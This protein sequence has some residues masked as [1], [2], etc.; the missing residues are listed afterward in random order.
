V[1]INK[2]FKIFDEKI[3]PGWYQRSRAEGRRAHFTAVLE[4]LHSDIEVVPSGSWARGTSLDPI[5][6]VDLILVLP[7]D[8]RAVYD[9]GSGS[10]EAVLKYVAALVVEMLP[11]VHRV[12]L[13]NHVVR[14]YLDST[15]GTDYEG[16]RGFAV[17][18]M[19][20]FRDGSGVKVPERRDDRWRTVDPENL[21]AA[22]HRRQQAW[23][24]YT[25]MVRLL[26]DWSREHP[27]LHISPL[28]MEVLALRCLPHPPW[29]RRM[30][31][32]EALKRFFTAAA[33]EIMRGVHD[34]AGRSGEIAPGLHRRAARKAFLEM[35][36]LAAT[37]AEWERSSHPEREDIT[38]HFLRQIFGKR[39]PKPKH[40]WKQSDFDA[41]HREKFG[42]TESFRYEVW[43]PPGFPG[44]HPWDGPNGGNKPGGG[45]EGGPRRPG[46]GPDPTPPPGKGPGPAPRPGRNPGPAPR[47][48]GGPGSAPR[49]DAGPGGEARPRT[50]ARIGDT[51]VTGSGTLVGG[52]RFASTAGHRVVLGATAAVAAPVVVRAEDPAG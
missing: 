25:A 27:E 39:F 1:N 19:P 13:R 5:H 22:S 14:C 6:D 7:D 24:E 41:W 23:P 40:D 30:S 4:M 45:P 38:V 11:D 42:P 34:P 10:A 15:L 28:A 48:G 12:E 21:I 47:P 46:S 51:L 44:G 32:V 3:T 20:A 2:A 50:G 33:G 36:D 43:T 18:V 49:P 37:A 35:A 52:S 31:Q 16:W 29:L 26:K 8:L 17:E 9:A